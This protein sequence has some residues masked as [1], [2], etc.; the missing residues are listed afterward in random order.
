MKRIEEEELKKIQLEILKYIDKVCRSNNISYTIA[1]GTLIGAV[2]HKGYIPWDDD[3][4]IILLREDYEKLLN[5]LYKENDKSN[6]QIMSLKEEDYYYTFA[7]VCDKRTKLVERNWGEIQGLGV[8]VDI[9]PFDGWPEEGIEECFDE[10]NKIRRN[11]QDCMTNIWYCHKKRYMRILKY[12]LKY[13]KI[14]KKRKNGADF[15]KKQLE[16]FI[17]NYDQNTKNVGLLTSGISHPVIV[18]KKV[19]DEY[20][21]LEFEN[22]KFMAV[23]DF[24]TLLK[25]EYGDYMKLPPVEQR[26]SNHDFEAYWR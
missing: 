22:E 24:D 9:F 13:N 11:I 8:Y 5:I 16:D 25:L 21:E 4:D 3:I 23:K 18:P 12:I 17:K 2:R 20:I 10:A 6:Y 26:I 19:F 14:K 15:Y 7:K 1:Y